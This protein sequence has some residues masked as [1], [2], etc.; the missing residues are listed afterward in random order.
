M[1]ETTARRKLQR[2][3]D[4]SSLRRVAKIFP[5]PGQYKTPYKTPSAS[6]ISRWYEGG[7]IPEWAIN[8]LRRRGLKPAPRTSYGIRVPPEALR[9]Q[10]VSIALTK[11]QLKRLKHRIKLIRKYQNPK[12]T[13]STLVYTLVDHYLWANERQKEERKEMNPRRGRK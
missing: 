9:D 1:N 6:T 2:L 3:V 5:L 10:I 12:M 7:P 4:R 13:V 11:G 8:R